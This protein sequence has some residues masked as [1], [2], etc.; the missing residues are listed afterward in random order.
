MKNRSGID[1]KNIKINFTGG[2]FKS[3]T[4]SE[5]VMSSCLRYEVIIYYT[6]EWTEEALDLELRQK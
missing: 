1:I 3:K 6:S 5:H 4:L 2:Y